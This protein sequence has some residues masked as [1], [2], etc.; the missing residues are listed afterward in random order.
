MQWL[1]SRG[2]KSTCVD[3]THKKRGRPPLKAEDSSLRSYTTHLDNPT[4]PAEAQPTMPP[5]RNTMHRATSSR[6]LRPMTD[7]QGLGDTS[8]IGLQTPHRWSASVFPLTRPMDPSPTMS[9]GVSR[10]PFSSSGPPSHSVHTHPYVPSGYMPIT[11]GFNPALKV[12]TMPGGMERRFP[13]YGVPALPPP[14]SPPQHQPPPVGTPFL[15]YTETLGNP[16][17]PPISD[18]RVPLS[19]RDP[20]NIE[21]PVRL[22]PIH[23]ATVGP[24]PPHHV[25]RLSDPYPTNWTISG[26]EDSFDDP[27][28]PSFH[29]SAGPAFSYSLPHQRS[30]SITSATMDP[31]PRHIGTKELPSPIQIKSGSSPSIARAEPPSTD[32]ED[33]DNRPIKRRKMALDD[34]VNG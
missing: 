15:P 20:Y 7:L 28:A 3:V 6:E 31:T 22:P 1:T 27:R 24:P 30:S 12:N 8:L 16:I 2:Q 17:R 4:V 9:G 33:Q 19:P 21:S 25:H 11:G 26:R 14:T 29:R 5:R 10:R 13:T 34:M 23:Q 18:P 32:A